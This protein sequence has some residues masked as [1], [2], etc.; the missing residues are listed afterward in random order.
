MDNKALTTSAM[1]LILALMGPDATRRFEKLRELDVSVDISQRDA[2]TMASVMTVII[3]T[4]TML[5]SHE[6]FDSEII[7]ALTSSIYALGYR[8]CEQKHKS[9]FDWDL[10]DDVNL[11][12]HNG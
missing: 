10:L 5:G 12:E 6:K 2:D 3:A 8:A 1:N 11:G 9:K 7:A 4:A